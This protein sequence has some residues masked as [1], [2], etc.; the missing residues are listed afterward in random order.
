MRRLLARQETLVVSQTVVGP[1]SACCRPLKDWSKRP[2]VPR[3]CIEELD[4][5]RILADDDDSYPMIER[6]CR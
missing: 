3:A 2:K 6:R 1:S 4:E 5:S